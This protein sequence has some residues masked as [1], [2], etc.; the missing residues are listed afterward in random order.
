MTRIEQLR[1]LV[2]LS[3]DDPLSHYALGLEYT[4]QG[5]H[6]DAIAAYDRALGRD[7]KYVA[8]YYHKARAQIFAGAREAARATLDA[9]ME[10]ARQAGDE[11]TW[12]EMQ[13]L[14]DTAT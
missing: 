5:A 1:R 3:P 7:V 4:N 2:E 11:K 10:V 9:G 13:D 6:A 12:R 14:R 8:A